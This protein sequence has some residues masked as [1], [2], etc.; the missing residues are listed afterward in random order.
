[1]LRRLSIFIALVVLGACGGAEEREAHYIERGK[2]L[3]QQGDLEDAAL[4]FRNA[5]QINPRGA[6]AL[7]HLGLIAEDQGEL[8]EAY[9]LYTRLVDHHPEH[10]LGNVKLGNL[11]LMAGEIDRAEE[12]ADLVLRLQSE[13]ADA[14]A[15]RGA[16]L[17]RRDR[18]ADAQD[19]AETALGLEPANLAATSVLAG[20]LWA[21]GEEDQ[22]FAVLDAYLEAHPTARP[23]RLLKLQMHLSREDV[24]AA[25]GVLNELIALEPSNLAHR[26]KLARILITEDRLDDAE[27]TLH[28]AIAQAPDDTAPKLLLIDLLFN[29]RGLSDAERQLLAF[30]DQEPAEFTYRFTLADLLA[31]AEEWER[32]EETYRSII[33]LG[34]GSVH[35]L[36]ARAGI[37]RGRAAVGDFEVVDSLI[38][39]VLE[40][41]PQNAQA[42]LLRARLRQQR[43]DDLG[44]IADSRSVLRD[45]PDSVPALG[46]LA[47]A[48]ID[49]QEIDLAIETLRLLAVADPG[50]D[51]VRLALAQLLFAEGDPSAALP[52]V[53][54][55][56]EHQADSAPAL[57]L[58][59]RILLAERD[60]SGAL[61]AADRLI[62]AGSATIGHYLKGQ[63]YYISGRLDSALAEFKTAMASDP[64]DPRL[65]TAVVQTYV[66]RESWDEAVTFLQDQVATAERPAVIHNL[67]GEVHVAEQAA[68]PAL[69]AFA[70]AISYEPDWPEPY[71][72]QG[73]ILLGSGESEAAIAILRDGLE[74]AP[75]DQSLALSL[76]FA[77][78]DA[79][80]YDA[81]IE[82]YRR[83]MREHG[84]SD[85]PVNNAASLIADFQYS[86]RGRLEWALALAERFQTSEVPEFLDTLGWLHYRLGAY[87]EA[88]TYLRRASS[89]APEHEQIR[90]HLGMTYFRLGE[91]ELAKEAL[92]EAVSE[93]SDY[94]G[95]EEAKATL[96]ALQ[97]REPT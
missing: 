59:A 51:D 40:A 23:P 5:L 64:A 80:D 48:H 24:P 85:I 2:T 75:D 68:E 17:L 21:Q 78:Q 39:E 34:E 14:L 19:V 45:D 61:Q 20:S 95:I 47:E 55:V 35:A 10:V 13:N 16:V 4:E 27:Q 7:Y 52:I 65:M 9:A 42:L 62:E 25:I 54:D 89:L 46:T 15:L 72:S 90:Y 38:A 93:G 32:A 74:H 6:D 73:R 53:T 28:D 12:K 77:Y 22:A 3:Y 63:A 50:N 56:V 86:N 70:E 91:L 71:L 94:V 37:A 36:T 97:P 44:A 88:L 11:L 79:Q 49:R 1:M 29:Q 33:E 31:R 18:A 67:I 30:I 26:I 87:T 83:F 69:A 66:A 82:Q 60:G 76:A 81:A 43:G 57:A 84:E 41:D 58:Q 92:S 96:G 8:Y